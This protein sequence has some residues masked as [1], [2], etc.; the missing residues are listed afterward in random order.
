MNKA[1]AAGSIGTPDVKSWTSALDEVYRQSGTLAGAASVIGYN[2]TIGE[3]TNE[4]VPDV[5]DLEYF[6]MDPVLLNG[7]QDPVPE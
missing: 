3:G 5:W 2:L 6:L 1:V 4:G 7:E